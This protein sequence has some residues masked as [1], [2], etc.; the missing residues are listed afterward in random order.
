VPFSNNIQ[1]KMKRL[2]LLVIISLILAGCG[3]MSDQD[4]KKQAEER[5]SKKD[6]AGAVTT[7]ETL[8]S[9]YPDSKLAPE[10][11][12]KMAEFYQYNLVK[13]ISQE[14][15]L[16]KAAKLY[17]DFYK[18]Y[19][20]NEASPKALF[21]SAFILANE[22]I[23]DYEEATGRYNLFIEKFPSHYLADEAREEIKYMGIPA[24][25]ILERKVAAGK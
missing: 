1:K 19:P 23:N 10:A 7:Y 11:L 5:L 2:I 20:D 9:E 13:D 17:F 16:K 8:I 3:K 18:K 15:S 6:T 21:M 25:E 14:E 24:G 12:Q 22:P 4:L